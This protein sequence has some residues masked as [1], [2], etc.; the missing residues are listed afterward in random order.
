MDIQMI[1]V[2]YAAYEPSPLTPVLYQINTYESFSGIIIES[3]YGIFCSS[4]ITRFGKLKISSGGTLDDYKLIETY[5]KSRITYEE[6]IGVTKIHNGAYGPFYL[7][8][9]IDGVPVKNAE[10]SSGSYYTLYKSIK[11]NPSGRDQYA[12]CIE[13]CIKKRV[14]TDKE[15]ILERMMLEPEYYPTAVDLL[16]KGLPNPDYFRILESD[17]LFHLF[18]LLSRK[19]IL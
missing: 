14:I 3:Y 15:G 4:L 7:V 10:I 17:M 19:K 13:D 12:A 9:H 6:I 18:V 16:V 11:P 5:L 1:Q 8:T 2:I